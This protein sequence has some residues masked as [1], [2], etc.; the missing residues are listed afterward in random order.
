[1]LDVVSD[2][3]YST[4]I[5]GGM[6]AG[7]KFFFFSHGTLFFSFNMLLFLLNNYIMFENAS[8]T[9]SDFLKCFKI[10]KNS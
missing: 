7:L 1:M 2:S 5:Q 6:N 3:F 8:L 10:F 9:K 4:G